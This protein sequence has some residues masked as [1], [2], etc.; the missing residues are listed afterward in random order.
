M[1]KRL[2]FVSVLLMLTSRSLAQEAGIP[3]PTTL[4][5]SPPLGGVPTFIWQAVPDALLYTL[6]IS[7]ESGY[8]FTRGY[9]SVEVC[10]A[11]LCRVTLDETLFSD[12]YTW[13]V[14]TANWSESGQWSDSLTFQVPLVSPTL[15]SLT[16][17]N[18]FRWQAVPRM[19]CY[20]LRVEIAPNVFFDRWYDHSLI[21]LDDVCTAP[22]DIAF[23]RPPLRFWVRGFTVSQGVQQYSRWSA[24]L[25]IATP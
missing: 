19:Y 15:L 18:S 22:V 6:W 3:L 24:P 23:T 20:E 5:A 8:V 16:A 25:E 10:D 14:R 2:L 9:D 4:I 21:C 17:D 13:W 11:D 7:G 12:E 1:W